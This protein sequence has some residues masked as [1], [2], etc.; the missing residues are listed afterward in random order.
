MGHLSSVRMWGILIVEFKNTAWPS[1][2]FYNV[3]LLDVIVM[4]LLLSPESKEGVREGML[5][6]LW[7]HRNAKILFPI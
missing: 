7:V 4:E 2:A 5:L 1:L 3:A 6:G